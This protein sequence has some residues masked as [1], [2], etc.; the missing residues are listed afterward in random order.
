MLPTFKF[1]ADKI[2]DDDC[3]YKAKEEM[4]DLL[5]KV[6]QKSK[7]FYRLVRNSFMSKEKFFKVLEKEYGETENKEKI[8]NLYLY[9]TLDCILDSINIYILGFTKRLSYMMPLRAFAERYYRI[10]NSWIEDLE[11]DG[12]N[13]A[14]YLFHLDNDD[15]INLKQWVKD[16]F[17]FDF[18][19]VPSGTGNVE[20]NIFEDGQKPHNLIDVGFGY[21]QILPIIVKIWKTLFIDMPNDKKKDESDCRKLEHV[22]LMEQPELHLHPKLQEKLGRVLAHAVR[23]CEK[24]KYDVRFFVETHSEAI[25]NAIGSEIAIN[26]LNNKAV[27]VLLF[28]AQSEG[29]DKYVETSHY[30]EDGYLMNWP[31]GFLS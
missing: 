3:S 4:M 7:S 28:N 25:I 8:N 26:G 18:E 16:N 5:P 2:D 12:R 27:N 13:L 11:P 30:S 14:M 15:K 21:S 9:Y 24:N 20:I 23:I 22:I 31:I 6:E 19:V 17:Q 29:M 1:W 10:Q